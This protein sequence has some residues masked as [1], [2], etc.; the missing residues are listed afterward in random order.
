MHNDQFLLVSSGTYLFMHTLLDV[1]QMTCLNCK[2]V[3]N[4]SGPWGCQSLLLHASLFTN[5]EYKSVSEYM[6]LKM[7]P[8]RWFIRLL[9][10][11]AAKCNSD[12]IN[13]LHLHHISEWHSFYSA[14]TSEKSPYLFFFKICLLNANI[15]W[16]EMKLIYAR[17]FI[18]PCVISWTYDSVGH[19]QQ[20]KYPNLTWIQ[21]IEILGTQ[22]QLAF[23]FPQL[24]VCLLIMWAGFRFISDSLPGLYSNSSLHYQTTGL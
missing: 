19:R 23:S 15:N 12:S 5:G 9:T 10:T 1:H 14:T 16:F 13:S 7:L 20:G 11:F 2:H 8:D 18:H 17:F 22:L 3:S 24:F 4:L 21:F 6:V